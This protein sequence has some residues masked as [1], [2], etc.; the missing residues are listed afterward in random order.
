MNKFIS[1]FYKNGRWTNKS[2]RIFAIVTGLLILRINNYLISPW[3]VINFDYP[4]SLIIS[5]TILILISYGLIKLYD[6][7]ENDVLFI[8]SLK[9]QQSRNLE[10]KFKN[11]V[12]KN[13]L[14]FSKY[15]SFLLTIVVLFMGPLITVV[16]FRE[17]YALYNSIPNKK[18]ALLFLLSSVLCSASW[19]VTLKGAF[20]LLELINIF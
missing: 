11:S 9:R 14:R 10:S 12:I 20:S 3:I 17:G 7:Q 2:R 18:I 19:V 6:R 4:E 16:Y 8:E 1:A 13:L 15:G 5:N